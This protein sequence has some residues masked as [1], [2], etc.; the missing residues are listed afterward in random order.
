MSSHLTPA[1]L[2]SATLALALA[3]TVASQKRRE[4]FNP[5]TEP[6]VNFEDNWLLFP[7]QKT[8]HPAALKARF[9]K[10]PQAGWIRMVKRS[11]RANSKV[12]QALARWNGQGRV[13]RI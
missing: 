8:F 2:I 3:Q 10:R 4:M 13:G 5:L 1:I 11:T 6:V 12:G 9:E 7:I